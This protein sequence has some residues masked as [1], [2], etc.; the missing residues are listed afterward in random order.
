M[1]D[2]TRFFLCSGQISLS[3]L[4]EDD[5][6]ENVFGNCTFTKVK[7]TENQPITVSSVENRTL[8]VVNQKV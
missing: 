6:I 7:P 4:S 1:T 5:G 8:G 3:V 2:A